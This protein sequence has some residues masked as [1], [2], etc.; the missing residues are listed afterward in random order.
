VRRF[1]AAD[2]SSEERRQIL[3]DCGATVVALGPHERALGTTGLQDQ[4]ELVPIYDQ[5]GV[6]WFRVIA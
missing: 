3:H 1:Y 4:P 2:A 6:A 5:D